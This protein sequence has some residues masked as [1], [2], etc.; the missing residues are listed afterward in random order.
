MTPDE[1]DA[2]FANETFIDGFSG[3]PMKLTH[4]LGVCAGW[5]QLVHDLIRDLIKLGWD[6]NIC[7]IKEK[8]GGL[9]FY[10]NDG[11]KEIFDRIYKAESESGNICLSCGSKVDVSVAANSYGWVLTLCK[12][13]RDTEEKRNVHGA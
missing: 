12:A 2:A 7:Q 8:F 10:I 13:C 6:R 3:K 5:C 4:H 9:R 11:S 1:F